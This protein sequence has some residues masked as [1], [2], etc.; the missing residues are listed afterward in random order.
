MLPLL[1]AI[2]IVF[3]LLLVAR[4]G[5]ARRGLLL[6]RWPALAM[7]A[8]AL[9][10]LLRGAVW[11]GIAFAALAALAW[12]LQPRLFA[13]APPPATRPD[14]PQDREARAILGLSPGAGPTEIRAAYRAK[15]RQA[16]PDRGGTHNEAARLAA[17]RDRLLKKR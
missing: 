6:K 9:L 11:P 8:V 7:A 16:H 10:A 4:L 2:A 3:A 15:M 17:A 1:I 13:P 12:V 5:G 14:D